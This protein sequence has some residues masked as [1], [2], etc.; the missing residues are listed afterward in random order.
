LNVKNGFT[1]SKNIVSKTEHINW[2]ESQKK[3]DANI[4]IAEE[5]NKNF[6]GYIRSEKIKK[7]HIISISLNDKYKNKNIGTII[8]KKFLKKFE[9]DNL[10]FLAIV[11]KTNLK[12]VKFFK[13]NDFKIINIAEI[14]KNEL[15][16]NYY[17][18]LNKN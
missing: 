14:R 7:Y 6:I 13:K 16:K 18:K 3:K 5:L 9:T 17:L 11:K 12:S 2:L 4:F 10:S 8:L 1:N 15:K